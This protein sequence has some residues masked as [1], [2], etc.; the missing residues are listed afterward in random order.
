MNR[1]RASTLVLTAIVIRWVGPRLSG[2]TPAADLIEAINKRDEPQAALLLKQGAN[3]NVCD[4]VTQ[5]AT[6]GGRRLR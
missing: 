3:P 2:Q 4:A 5:P 6:A 1:S